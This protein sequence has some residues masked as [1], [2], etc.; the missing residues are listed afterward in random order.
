[1]TKRGVAFF[2]LFALLLF[3]ALATGYSEI[4]L[5]ALLTGMIFA[6]ALVSAAAGAFVLRP[7]LSLSSAKVIRGQK[8]KVTCAF[9]ESILLPV[10]VQL[11]LGMPIMK[12][13]RAAGFLFGGSCRF[14]AA[15]F[16]C[17][18]RGYWPIGIRKMRCCDLF[19]FFSLPSVHK[20]I[21]VPLPLM[22]YPNL[23][24]IPV[25]PPPPPPALEYSENNPMAADQG[26]GFADTRLYHQ[27]DPLKRIHWKMSVRTG[28]LHT[29][30]Y[31]MPLNRSVAIVIDTFARPEDPE[32]AL[33]YADMACEA[34]LAL[35]MLYTDGGY[36]V[37][38]YSAGESGEGIQISSPEDLD[39]AYDW[40]ASVSFFSASPVVG[41]V[42]TLTES[43]QNFAAFHV[44]ART[45]SNELV[46]AM[47][48]FPAPQRKASIIFPDTTGLSQTFTVTPEGLFLIPIA[49]PGDIPERL[50]E[51]I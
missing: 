28:E 39:T 21:H 15:E 33:H 1:M 47:S 46:D 25:T 50:G 11:T 40:L 5:M 35:V 29:L 31:E 14:P 37:R 41:A 36:A 19:G 12:E 8:V 6:F 4:F 16:S 38:L 3:S 34:A 10:I 9:G 17:P 22:V 23:Y 32:S 18:H 44:I 43:L 45:P 27:G 26:D 42:L 7:K 48:S 49:C 24:D 30:Q 2:L 13:Y 20:D 51:C